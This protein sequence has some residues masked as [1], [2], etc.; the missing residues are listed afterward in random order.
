MTLM[1]LMMILVI[2]CL[3]TTHVILLLILIITLIMEKPCYTSYITTHQVLCL[4]PERASHCLREYQSSN[5]D[6]Y[7]CMYTYIYIYIYIYN[8]DMCI[9]IYIYTHM[10]ILTQRETPS[11]EVRF[12]DCI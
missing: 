9:Y 3:I 1:I 7:I 11:P 10:Y 6:M 12:N 5:K 8:A 4:R 2:R